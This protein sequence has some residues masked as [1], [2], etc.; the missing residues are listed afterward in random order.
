MIIWG[1]IFIK[2]AWFRINNSPLSTGVVLVV[3]AL[4][5]KV[6]QY[7]CFEKVIKPEG[8]PIWSKE[9]VVCLILGHCEEGWNLGLGMLLFRHICSSMVKDIF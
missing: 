2:A 6:E 8:W 5:F 7:F 9:S 1:K 4:L 3:L